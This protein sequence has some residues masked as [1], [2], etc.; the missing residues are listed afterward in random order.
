MF[1]GPRG[2]F[3]CP[4]STT[5]CWVCPSAMETC[6][7]RTVPLLAWSFEVQ[8]VCLSKFER[9]SP[10]QLA[11]I[12]WNSKSSAQ[13]KWGKPIPHKKF[14]N[15]SGAQ[16]SVCVF[17]G[18]PNSSCQAT[19]IRCHQVHLHQVLVLHLAREEL[20]IEFF[21]RQDLCQN[22]SGPFNYQW[23]NLG[24][25]ETCSSRVWR[26]QQLWGRQQSCGSQKVK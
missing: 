1:A 20:F 5:P 6:N 24:E 19:V 3:H 4:S 8:N 22:T 16:K 26:F 7:S 12:P 21:V 18:S 13:Q 11:G 15:F 2:C 25:K 10:T 17:F 14:H 23:S 9:S